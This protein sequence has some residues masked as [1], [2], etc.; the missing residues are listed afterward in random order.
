MILL[1]FAG[2]FFSLVLF[3]YFLDNNPVLWAFIGFFVGFFIYLNL[4]YVVISSILLILLFLILLVLGEFRLIDLS[5]IYYDDIIHYFKQTKGIF[6]KN[7]KLIFITGRQ[8]KHQ[9]S[10]QNESKYYEPPQWGHYNSERKNEIFEEPKRKSKIFSDNDSNSRTDKSP[11]M[12]VSSERPKE[13]KYKPSQIKEV[14][15]CKHPDCDKTF[16]SVQSMEQHYTDKHLNRN[17]RKRKYHDLTPY[18]I[19]LKNLEKGSA[20]KNKN[21]KRKRNKKRKYP[22]LTAYEV[23]MRNLEKA[24]RANKREREIKTG[25]DGKPSKMFKPTYKKKYNQDK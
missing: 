14:Y 5:Q 19:R 25:L 23:R 2:F 11:N 9:K 13:R 7:L 22:H 6:L 10:V 20:A 24:H 16:N 4:F 17:R 18:E 15:H 8:K 21:K 3:I 12:S 1:L